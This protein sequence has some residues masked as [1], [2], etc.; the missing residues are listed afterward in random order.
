MNKIISLLVLLQLSG[1]IC[2]QN[3]KI[4]SKRA[5]DISQTQLW[6]KISEN[7]TLIS[8]FEHLNTLNFY[9]ITYRSDSIQVN[10]IL[11]EP[12]KDEKYPVVIFNRGG[13][14]DFAPLTIST[15]IL[16]TSK[17]AAQGY[18]I[19]G[20][21]YREKDEFGGS[22]INDVLALTETVKEIKKANPDRIGMFGWSRGGMM[23]Y[24]ALQ[25]SDEI[26]T[27]IVGNA[28]TD[29]F[30]IIADRP[31]LES[32]VIAACIPGYW[33]HKDTELKKRSV[34][35]WSDELSKKSSL[36]ILCGTRDKRVNPV[37]ADKIAKDLT[38]LNYDFEL[39]KFETD[40]FFSDKKKELNDVVIHWFNDRLKK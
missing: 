1:Y 37:Q 4:L 33:K 5:V 15:M 22:E 27:A 6:D 16:Y 31:A 36:L 40:H 28:P 17:L 18:V 12:K 23:T 25:K 9:F 26:K 38:K 20:S 13:N 7:D 21:N 39:K 3:G 10:G 19:V 11:I 24:L 30:G 8:G 32:K 29:L 2:A 34:I 14:R 35:Y